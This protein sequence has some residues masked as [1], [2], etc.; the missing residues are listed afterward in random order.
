MLGIS[1]IK[2]KVGAVRKASTKKVAAKRPA[3]RK[4]AAKKKR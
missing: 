2:K 1:K 4:T 3:A